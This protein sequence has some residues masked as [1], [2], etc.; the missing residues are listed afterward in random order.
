M[1]WGGTG[2]LRKLYNPEVSFI[3]LFTLG[4]AMVSSKGA[5]MVLE[6]D[7]VTVSHKTSPAKMKQENTKD[8]IGNEWK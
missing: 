6:V 5:V 8:N 2:H 7:A 1:R 3:F 4:A